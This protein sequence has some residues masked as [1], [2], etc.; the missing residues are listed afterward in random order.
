MKNKLL[1]YLARFLGIII[2]SLSLPVFAKQATL[3]KMQVDTTDAATRIVFKLTQAINKPR[4]YA[5]SKP[6]RLVIDFEGTQLSSGLKNF[7]FTNTLIK[8]VR[9]GQ[10]SPSNLRLVLEL[11]SPIHWNGWIRSTEVIVNLSP[12]RGKLSAHVPITA[13]QS[14][15][16]QAKKS[17]KSSPQFKTAHPV[18]IVID[19]G[20]GGKDSG[21]VGM[22]GTKEKDVVLAIAKRLA[23]LI[24]AEPNMRAE[25]TRHG[26]YFVPLRDRI[27]LARKDKADLF[28]AIH[29]DSYFH[30]RA[31]GASVY[32]L[33]QRGA[34]SEAARWLA[35]RDNYSELDG[36]NLGELEDKSPLVRLV[37]IDLAQTTTI[38]DSLRLGR[39]L[40]DELDDITKLHHARVEQAPFVVLKSPD[41]P[42]ILVETGFISNGAEEMRLRDKRYQDK[43]ARALLNG[44]KKYSALDA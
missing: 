20:H 14:S 35:K 41:I 22:L 12:T 16:V 39:T 4:V 2:L 27:K 11:S 43:I 1:I 7:N 28:I 24:N 38:S 19:A 3:T 21:A 36:V 5:L 8:Q 17:S 25:L 26:D 10:P 40:L 23:V 9:A 6:S 29:A 33:S 31:R 30:P 37:L 34:T 13:P 42:S 44:V 32:A 18:I 15:V